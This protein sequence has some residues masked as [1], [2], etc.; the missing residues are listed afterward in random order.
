MEGANENPARVNTVGQPRDSD[1]KFFDLMRFIVVME[2]HNKTAL[3]MCS[4]LKTV[5]CDSCGE[6]RVR[7][8]T[9]ALN[10]Q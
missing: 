2:A 9:F 10:H 1:K 7:L 5:R 3:V 4:T 8:I 6:P